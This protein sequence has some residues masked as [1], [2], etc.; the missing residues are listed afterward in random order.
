MVWKTSYVD[1][2]FSSVGVFL[3]GV[4]LYILLKV[5]DKNTDVTQRYI[6]TNLCIFDFCSCITLTVNESLYVSHIN[7]PKAAEIIANIFMTG[8]YAATLWLVF[9]RYLHV[10]LNLKYHLYWSKKKT[11][12]FTLVLWIFSILTATLFWIFSEFAL[13]VTLVVFDA[14]II[15][16]SAFVYGS[17]LIISRQKK[18]VLC[19]NRRRKPVFKGLLLT[20]VI[21]FSYALLMA[22]PDV[23]IVCT[24]SNHENWSVT[25]FTYFNSSYVVA[26]WV[27]ALVYIVVSPQSLNFMRRRIAVFQTQHKSS[28][29]SRH[30]KST[31]IKPEI[32]Q[33]EAKK[34]NL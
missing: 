13:F 8:Y 24:F 17:A 11:I 23:I 19:C 32:S 7:Y 9:D 21:L 22:V 4:G 31:P 12:I 29:F 26:M 20:S 33:R 6:I 2:I 25:M 27:D 28:I 30:K 14:I 3:N 1:I 34:S 10:K 18:K 15:L 16:F 5:R